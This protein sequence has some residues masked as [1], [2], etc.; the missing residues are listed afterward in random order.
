M[1]E[2]NRGLQLSSWNSI[3]CER[4]KASCSKISNEMLREENSRPH[5]GNKCWE[6]LFISI[7]SDGLYSSNSFKTRDHICFRG[8]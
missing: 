3:S 1:A 5:L 7:C 6:G 2:G 4:V 8:P